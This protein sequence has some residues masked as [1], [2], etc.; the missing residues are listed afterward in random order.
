MNLRLVAVEQHQPED[1]PASPGQLPPSVERAIQA[2]FAWNPAGAH[3]TRTAVMRM[4]DDGQDPLDV[5]RAL[6]THG[7]VVE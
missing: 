6:D 5:L 2:R 4:L 3:V 1:A 7:E